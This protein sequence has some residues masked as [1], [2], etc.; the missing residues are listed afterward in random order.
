[1]VN[2]NFLCGCVWQYP[3]FNNK[4]EKKIVLFEIISMGPTF[5]VKKGCP[6]VT[7][8]YTCIRRNMRLI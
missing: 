6:S 5:D 3:L 4:K 2:N 8:M 1:M 7:F